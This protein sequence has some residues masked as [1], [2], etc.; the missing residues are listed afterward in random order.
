[1]ALPYIE[2]SSVLMEMQQYAEATA[3]AEKAIALEPT[4]P[5]AYNNRGVLL[6]LQAKYEEA[7]LDYTKAIELSNKYPAAH[8]TR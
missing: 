3:D 5:E 7:I 4:S 2:R 6:R 1:M 8:A